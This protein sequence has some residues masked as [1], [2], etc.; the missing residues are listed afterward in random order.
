MYGYLVIYTI[1]LN[2]STFRT[3]ILFYRALSAVFP[4][5]SAR[6]VARLDPPG[7]RGTPHRAG[8]DGH[9][10]AGLQ[11]RTE[12][13]HGLCKIQGLVGSGW[14]PSERDQ[15]LYKKGCQ[16]AWTEAES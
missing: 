11:L 3:P 7:T 10:D 12:A 14:R 9:A 2:E 6:S 13:S 8:V 16:K 5:R 15:P 4:P 1:E